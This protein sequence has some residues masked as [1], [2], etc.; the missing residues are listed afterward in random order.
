MKAG[1][2]APRAILFATRPR[3]RRLTIPGQSIGLIAPS[4]FIG[5]QAIRLTCLS[6]RSTFGIFFLLHQAC[7]NGHALPLRLPTA[8]DGENPILPSMFPSIRSS[9]DSSHPAIQRCRKSGCRAHADAFYFSQKGGFSASTP[10]NFPP[11]NLGG[12]AT[13]SGA[14]ELAAA[15][16]SQDLPATQH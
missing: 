3:P 15:S 14:L 8:A 7:S 12:S 13:C 11:D 2:S 10:S 5:P 16:Q 9:V 6:S 1:A 4:Q